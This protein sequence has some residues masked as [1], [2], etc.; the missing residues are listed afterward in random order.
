MVMQ[1]KT[2]EQRV[3]IGR[4][5]WATLS[6]ST[7]SHRILSSEP[8]H[9]VQDGITEGRVPLAVTSWPSCDIATV[10]NAGVCFRCQHFLNGV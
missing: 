5:S 7:R 6:L 2:E 1:C 10:F 8:D 3:C 9:C 4:D